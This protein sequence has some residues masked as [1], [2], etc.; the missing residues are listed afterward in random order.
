M[1]GSLDISRA[2]SHHNGIIDD[3]LCMVYGVWCMGC[4]VCGLQ[5]DAFVKEFLLPHGEKCFRIVTDSVWDLQVQLKMEAERKNVPLA[6][7]YREYYDLKDEFRVLYPWFQFSN[8]EPPL[9]VMLK[10]F[11]LDFIGR[12]H[13]GID[14]C[15]TIC[16]IAKLMLQ[17]GMY[18]TDTHTH[19]H[20]LSPYTH[21]SHKLTLCL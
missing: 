15:R 19:I 6:W 10:A 3:L 21:Y 9:F 17:L 11:G 14:D 20:S 18:H 5:F 12:H 4:G 2:T 8:K 1:Y 13:S 7:W 16:Q